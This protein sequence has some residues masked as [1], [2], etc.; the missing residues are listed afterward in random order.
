MAED[1]VAHAKQEA[2]G[3]IAEACQMTMEAFKA[4]TDFAWEK[5]QQLRALRC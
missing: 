5:A 2:E 4:S 1:Q 3:R